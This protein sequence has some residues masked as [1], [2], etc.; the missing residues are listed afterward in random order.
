MRYYVITPDGQ[1][2]GPA[3]V[4]TLNEWA[5]QGRVLPEFIFEEETTG[6]RVAP[7]TVSGINWNVGQPGAYY[8]P[9]SQNFYQPPMGGPAYMGG[10]KE[11]SNAWTWAVLSFICCPV[12][13]GILGVV[14]S[15]RARDLGNPG[16]RGPFILSIVSLVVTVIM[17]GTMH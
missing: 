7:M 9:A 12:I 10:T 13:G 3:D 1:R 2:Y 4:S 16:Y 8:P 17:F 15:I 5:A 14:Y 11:L 6:R